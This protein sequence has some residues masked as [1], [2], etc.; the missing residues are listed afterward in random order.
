M[1]DDMM[2]RMVKMTEICQMV[3]PYSYF[4][5]IYSDNSL[6]LDLNGHLSN[7]VIFCEIHPIAK[8]RLLNNQQDSLSWRIISLFIILSV[9][10]VLEKYIYLI[11]VVIQ[12]G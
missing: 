6:L 2:C 4:A 11:I 8:V 3:Q 7:T 12:E 9:Q 5:W 10:R 1:Y